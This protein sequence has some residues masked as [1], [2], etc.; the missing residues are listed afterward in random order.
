MSDAILIVGGY[1]AVG[2][3]V[4]AALA[5]AHGD[6]LILAGR[7]AVRAAAQAARL[8]P[9]VRWRLL[10]A[11]GPV[12]YDD[13]LA[14]VGLVV[15]CLDA[16]NLEFVRQCFQRGIHYVDISAEYPILSAIAA[17]DEVARQHG[18]T[19]V[20]SVGLAPGLSNLMARHSLRFVDPIAHFDSAILAGLGEKHGVAGSTWILN[21]MNDMD[22]MN[23]LQFCQPY[24]R[25][26]VHRFA[27]SD[28][29][30]LPHTLPI[31]EAATWLGF[32]S[33]LMTQLVGLARRPL[34]RGLFRREAV[35]RA[36]LGLTQRFQ[37][38]SEEFVLTTRACGGTGAY[39]AWL[40]GTR[41][42]E[43]TGLVTA[44]IVHRLATEHHAPGVYHIEQL[45]ALEDVLPRLEQRGVTFSDGMARAG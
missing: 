24:D 10:D 34:L 37:F 12:D 28:Q 39:Q 11:A 38:G 43:V 19:A 35:K 32:D 15:M 44:E 26:P 1:G 23:R 7:N 13:V 4:A 6:Q 16:P 5:P 21:H 33:F 25:K 30:T 17:L 31:S 45:F 20:L 40:R 36:L 8:G 3:V 22:G 2:A 27:F 42:A 29:Y 14:D 18:A 41:E 9:R